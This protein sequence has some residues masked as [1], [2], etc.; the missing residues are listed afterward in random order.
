M[1]DPG[2]P[3]FQQ[4]ADLICDDILRGVYEE[5][6]QVASTNE[7]AAFYRINPATAGKGINQLV[8]RGILYKKRGIGMFVA[9]GAREKL[10][11]LRRA[12]FTQT[13]LR[14]FVAEARAIGLT[15]DEVQRLIT[16]EYADE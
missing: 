3:I 15:V 6:A 11:S 7:F 5:D 13:K 16:R 14:K 9:P 1:F 12:E 8:D 2:T 4:I 10:L